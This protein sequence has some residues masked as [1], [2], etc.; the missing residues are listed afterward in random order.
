LLKLSG[1]ESSDSWKFRVSPFL[2]DVLFSFDEFVAAVLHVSA[3]EI[4]SC[5]DDAAGGWA[6]LDW[7]SGLNFGASNLG[8]LSLEFASLD[9]F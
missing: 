4:K 5:L 9:L 1:T 7:S 3:F 8:G 6:L 2:L